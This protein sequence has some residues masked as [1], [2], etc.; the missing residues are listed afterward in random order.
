MLLRRL[1]R[2]II[3]VRVVRGLSIPARNI[4]AAPIDKLNPQEAGRR[5]KVPRA[6]YRSSLPEVKPT[7]IEFILGQV[8]TDHV[9]IDMIV[10]DEHKRQ[11]IG[12]P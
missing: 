10:V 4:V 1:H 2:E 12:Q 8:Q 7:V 9:V 3:G 11:P 5:E 6:C